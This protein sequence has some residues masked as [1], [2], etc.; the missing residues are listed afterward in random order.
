MYASNWSSADYQSQLSALSDPLLGELPRSTESRCSGDVERAAVC[1]CACCQE[2]ACHCH[3]DFDNDDANTCSSDSVLTILV[4][5]LLLLIQFGMPY[6]AYR[7]NS[8]YLQAAFPSFKIV[9]ASIILFAAASLL[10]RCSLRLTTTRNV[11]SA[12]LPEIWM[13]AVLAYILLT[14]DITRA[15]QLLLTGNLVLAACGMARGFMEFCEEDEEED[16]LDGVDDK[17]AT[18]VVLPV[19][20]CCGATTTCY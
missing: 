11:V 8:E 18:E 7:N 20:S 16:E 5:P 14:Q 15:L 12:L 2:S 3:D 9:V 1:C 4:L 19:V 17:R 10:Y 13:N 6:F